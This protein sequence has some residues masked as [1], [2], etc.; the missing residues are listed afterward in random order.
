MHRYL[1]FLSAMF[2]LA[3]ASAVHAQQQPGGGP[4]DNGG[5]PGRT[6]RRTRRRTGGG[7]GGPD[8]GPP[9]PEQ[10]RNM[11]DRRVKK[12][13]QVTDDVW[14]TL[15]PLIDNVQELEH[16]SDTGPLMHGPPHPDD[17]DGDN[18][19]DRPRSPIE[20]AIS[21]LK[22][23]LTDDASTDDQ[24]TQAMQAVENAEEKVKDD[25]QAA[26]KELKAAV[27]LRQQAVLV[28]LGIL[29]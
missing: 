7:P 8:G 27:N 6:G 13:M 17:Q 1:R 25:L 2:L 12:A 19:D 9:D 16:Q 20:S 29:D 4:G 15:K 24:V 3:A 10:M 22:K 21:N 28:A 23:V 26:R 11:M 14:S 18:Q 5:I